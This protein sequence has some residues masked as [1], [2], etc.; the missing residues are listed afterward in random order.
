MGALLPIV[1]ILPLFWLL[2]VRPQRQRVE[3][4]R[5]LLSSLEVGDQVVTA[6]GLVGTIEHIDAEYVGLRVADGVGLTLVRPAIARRTMG[7]GDSASGAAGA[8]SSP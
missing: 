5:Q 2:L 7:E 6:G 1:I 8:E 3:R 4:Q